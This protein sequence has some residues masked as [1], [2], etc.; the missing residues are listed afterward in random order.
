MR[1][2][3]PYNEQENYVTTER[4]FGKQCAAITLYPE[5]TI[6]NPGELEKLKEF[7]DKIAENNEKYVAKA[8]DKIYDNHFAEHQRISPGE[9]C[10][11]AIFKKGL[12]LQFVSIWGDDG[13]AMVFNSQVGILSNHNVC[14]SF[15][16]GRPSF[17]AIVGK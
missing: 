14:A 11:K 3:F 15:P 1:I 12:E 16:V 7:A 10:T 13:W 8:L 6:F 4:F 5:G 2:P 9:T 17:T